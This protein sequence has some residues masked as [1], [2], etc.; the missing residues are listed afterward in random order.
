MGGG[1][2][3]VSY[4]KAQAPDVFTPSAPTRTK[5]EAMPENIDQA[6]VSTGVKRT[7]EE[8]KLKSTGATSQLV[9]PLQGN[10]QSGGYVE[11]STA[12]GVV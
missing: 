2:G 10:T 12:T 9:I 3:T 4:I 6:A 1:S 8:N 5:A 11:P 7:E